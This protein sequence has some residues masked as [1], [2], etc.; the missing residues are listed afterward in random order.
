[1]SCRES[2]ELSGNGMPFKVYQSAFMSV[3]ARACSLQEVKE[4]RERKKRDGE[5]A[6][7]SNETSERERARGLGKQKPRDPE[8]SGGRRQR[9]IEP[10][11]GR[12]AQPP[13]CLRP[14]SSHVS[15]P[16][17]PR[18]F[19]PLDEPCQGR[20]HPFVVAP[21]CRLSR[22]PCLPVDQVIS[23]WWPS[24]L[25]AG[26]APCKPKGRRGGF[27]DRSV[28]R[29]VWSCSLGSWSLP[30]RATGDTVGSLMLWF[31]RKS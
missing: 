9:Y 19:Q 29:R 4:T 31:W 28:S 1:M 25:A 21:P 23:G 13:G 6:R 20:R 22:R 12:P 8:T 7:S 17:W 16:P 2:R 11:D 24:G 15:R 10:L 5:M 26:A 30:K 18:C 3:E 14:V 27:C